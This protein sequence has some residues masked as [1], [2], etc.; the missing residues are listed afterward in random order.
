[1]AALAEELF[2]GAPRV[3][4]LA[5]SRES[6]RAG[7]EWVHHLSPLECPPRDAVSLTATQALGFPAVQ[8]FVEQAAASGYPLELSDADAPIVAG[9]CR[10]LDGIALALELAARSAGVYGVQ[11]TA[12]L[13]DHQFSLLRGRRTATLRHQ[14]LTAT[15]DWSHGLLS[16]TERLV[17]RRLAIFVGAFSLEAA[18]TIVAHDL[19]A[20]QATKALARLV[21]KSL[22]SLDVSAAACYRLL[23]TTRAYALEKLATSGE[24]KSIA[25]RHAEY[26]SSGL[27]RFEA[28]AWKRLSAKGIDFFVS[29]LGDVRAALDWSFGADGDGNLGVRLAAAAVPL[30]FQRSHSSECVAWSERALSRLDPGSATPLALQLQTCFAMALMFIANS[31]AAHVALV[32]ALQLARIL[33][34]AVS[35]LLLLTAISRYKHRRGDWREL[36]DLASRCEALARQIEDPLANAIVRTTSAVTCHHLGEHVEALGHAKIALSHPAHSSQLNP[37]AFSHAAR[38]GALHVQARSLWMLGYPDQ[39][40]E[41]SREA[42]KEAERINHRATTIFALAHNAFVPLN[43]GDW[44]TAEDWIRRI[45][46]E[47]T[48]YALTQCH[49]VAI[50]Y[51]GVLA[52]RLGEPL[53]GTELLQTAA[54]RL[55]ADGW[56]SYRRVLTGELAEGLL[57]AGETKLA[58]TII[59]ETVDREQECG[60]SCHTPELLRVKGEVLVSMAQSEAE[61]CL[62]HSLTLAGDQHALSF[63]L[64]TGMS[65]ARLWAATGRRDNAL[66]LLSSIYSRFSEGFQTLDLVSAATLRD[67]LRSP[68]TRGG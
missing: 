14:T 24:Q 38:V 40:V 10:R 19:E 60:P 52:V 51:Q 11:G 27:E 31:P 68:T 1:V 64:R 32:R 25:R 12:A 7:G 16:E 34:D 15:L 46:A 53:R 43:T 28:T 17:L 13:L 62:L 42:I 37:V 50:G 65:L 36:R 41:A 9:L 66:E 3:H 20:A 49:S 67:E 39:A 23:D 61:Q 44:Q 4:L 8:L 26:F 58:H 30:F 29:Q 35:Q 2:Y 56:E 45:I 33:E 5:T 6:L 47:A 63:E 55:H 57:K 22:V 59:C 18:V 54:A 21:E 48:T